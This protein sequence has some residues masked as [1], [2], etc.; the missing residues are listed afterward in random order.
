MCIDAGTVFEQ[1]LALPPKKREELADK[2][3]ESL[4][5]DDREAIEQAWIAEV[6]KRVSDLKSQR[7]KPIPGKKVMDAIRKDILKK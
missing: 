6:R 4:A 7:V 1:A 3:W 2:L 5:E